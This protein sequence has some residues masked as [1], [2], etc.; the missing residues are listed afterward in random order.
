MFEQPKLTCPKCG[1]EQDDFDGFGFIYCP[2]CE[3][4]THPNSIDGVCGICGEEID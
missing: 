4:C 3:Y 1:A 2:E